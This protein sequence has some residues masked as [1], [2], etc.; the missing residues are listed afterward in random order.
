[1]HG[2]KQCSVIRTVSVV[3]SVYLYFYRGWSILSSLISLH[4]LTTLQRAKSG[5]ND[6]W[7]HAVIR[8]T[9]WQGTAWRRK[10]RCEAALFVLGAAREI[11]AA[12]GPRPRRDFGRVQSICLCSC[13]AFSS[14]S[15]PVGQ[16]LHKVSPSNGHR[17]LVPFWMFLLRGQ[18]RAGAHTCLVGANADL[19]LPANSS[20]NQRPSKK[21]KVEH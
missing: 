19:F 5:R 15:A 2:Y 13:A 17:L 3:Q 8:R 7:S 16:R 11:D 14:V 4:F 9:S 12:A 1:M 10:T 18:I 6:A 21:H 20:R